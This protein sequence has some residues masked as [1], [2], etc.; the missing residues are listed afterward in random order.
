MKTLVAVA[1]ADIHLS[2]DPPRF[3]SVEENWLEVQKKY[4]EQVFSI[5]W[6]NGVP[7]PL[8]IA[9]DIFDRAAPTPEI[10]NFA[11]DVFGKSRAS[12]IYA[13][14]GNHDL[15]NH[16]YEEMDRS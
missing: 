7:V 5:T 14:P 1:I 11:L 12:Y 3:R 4:L 8:L 6:N 9:G 15:P 16:R 10:I 2:V 13:I